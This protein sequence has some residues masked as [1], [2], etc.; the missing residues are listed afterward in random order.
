[1]SQ[2]LSEKKNTTHLS[3]TTMAKSI[4]SKVKRSFRSKKRESG[5]YAATE[6]ARL[7][8]LNTKLQQTIK[9]DQGGETDVDP[10]DAATDNPG[11]SWFVHLG[12]LDSSD[13]TLD[14]LSNFPSHSSRIWEGA[15]L[16]DSL[17]PQDDLL[18]HSPHSQSNSNH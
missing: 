11:W 10:M 3:P 18:I 14:S 13:I 6:A 5:V 2:N 15:T 17:F 16:L 4:R 7:Q 8:R 1:M 9:G 12:M